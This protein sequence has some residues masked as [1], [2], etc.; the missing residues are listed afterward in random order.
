V[1]AVDSAPL[2]YRVGKRGIDIAVAV[3]GLV[4]CSPVIA[5][6]MLAIKLDS[7]GPALYI[8][9]RV[10]LHG[11]QFMMYKLRTMA[12]GADD[13]IHRSFVAGLLVAGAESSEPQCEQRLFKIRDD[14]RIT[15]VGRFLRRTSLD[16]LPQLYNVLK[17]DMSLV[18][19]RPDV[20]Y[21]VEMYE[22]WQA[23]RLQAKPGMTGLW[24]V[25]GR[26]HLS[27]LTMFRLDAE[28]VER[29]NLRL[30]LQIMLRT[31]PVVVHRV[32]TE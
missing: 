22:P 26:G 15:R 28:Y 13:S 17:G 20:P 16:E 2:T 5:C 32:G 4:L 1:L 3:V 10:G 19:P 11:K 27:P 31:V 7:R 6:A 14:P 18:G 12:H 24:Q 25:S 8:A 29:R 30:D 21:A 9:P 23:R